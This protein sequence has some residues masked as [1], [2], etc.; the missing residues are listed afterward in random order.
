MFRRR[1]AL[2]GDAA[3]CMPPFRAQGLATGLHDACNISWKIASV[4]MGRAHE[5]LLDSY[6]RERLP[7]VRASIAAAEGMGSAICLRRP[8]LLWR[9]KNATFALA[10][11]IGLFE[12]L[13]RYFTPSVS[14][15]HGVIGCSHSGAAAAGA[16]VP[17]FCV[18]SRGDSQPRLFDEQFWCAR[19]GEMRWCI[20]A[21]Y[22][23]DEFEASDFKVAR[24]LH[25]SLD[26]VEVVPC[27]CSSAMA[28]WLRGLRSCAAL[29][30]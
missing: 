10:N 14:I 28:A 19:G 8:K 2:V 6:Q 23:G 27:H 25:G 11:A 15:L 16:P 26:L 22:S 17:N 3:H 4:L 12:V 20:V 1:V 21:I 13:F 9:V 7:H 29:V 5:Q 18:T 30:R 24:A